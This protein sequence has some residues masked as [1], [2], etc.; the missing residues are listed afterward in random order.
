MS[1][2]V[3]FFLCSLA[4]L[5]AQEK[6]ELA[7]CALFKNEADHLKEWIE[8]HRIIG[9]DHFYLY[10]NGSTDH[11]IKVL[12]PY[13]KEKVVTLVRWPDLVK[14]EEG[15]K[16][17]DWVL[18]TQI[19]AYENAIV[20]HAKTRAKWLV[21][22]DVEEFVVPENE[23]SILEILKKHH[24][25]VAIAVTTDCFDASFERISF[26]SRLVIDT[27]DLTKESPKD[28]R[29]RVRK[30]IFKP[31]A[32]AGSSWSPYQCQFKGERKVL[33]VDENEIRVNRYQGR[34]ALS[35]KQKRKVCIEKE[36]LKKQALD[37]GY[38]VQDQRRS[39]QRFIP[40]LS[41]RMGQ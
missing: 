12:K 20:F 18:S 4:S 40:E 7:V 2:W 38:D 24:M 29:E 22:L 13:I 6:H 19:P 33:D 11:S 15:R 3:F 8:Y 26:P 16:L 30:V 41:S 32:Y 21:F 27:D 35:I 39:I 17:T 34:N 14:K 25:E 1:R 5:G 10:D 31:D 9:V 28:A 36:D 37:A 23:D